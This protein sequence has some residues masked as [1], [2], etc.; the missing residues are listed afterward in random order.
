[1]TTLSKA[2]IDY[3]EKYQKKSLEIKNLKE[4]ARE[5]QKKYR[6]E[7]DKINKNIIDLDS[8]CLAM[9]H[10]ITR[11]LDDGQ[12]AVEARLSDEIELSTTLWDEYHGVGQFIVNGA[13][14]N[15]QGVSTNITTGLNSIPYPIPSTGIA[16][17]QC[18][19]R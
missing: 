4:Q 17:S 11:V 5:I 8:E 15:T 16:W 12:D 6:E 7:I 19:T 13:A 2:T 3:F 14:N 9:R 18:N 1:M 10:I